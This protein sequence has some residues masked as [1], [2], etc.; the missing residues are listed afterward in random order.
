M[1]YTKLW[2]SIPITDECVAINFGIL[3]QLKIE[4]SRF[5]W[6]ELRSN[7]VRFSWRPRIFFDTTPKPAL[8]GENPLN[9]I[10]DTSNCISRIEQVTF[11]KNCSFSEFLSATSRLQ[12]EN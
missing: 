10:V 11:K 6:S 12:N 1:Q 2:V 8:G 3:L 7:L 4:Y 5:E 9:L